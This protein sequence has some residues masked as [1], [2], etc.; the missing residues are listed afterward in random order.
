MKPVEHQGK[1]SLLHATVIPACFSQSDVDVAKLTVTLAHEAKPK[2]PKHVVRRYKLR[3][4][5]KTHD[6][7]NSSTRHVNYQDLP[8][9]SIPLAD[10]G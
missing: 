7:D 4:S 5:I 6:D 9:V 10:T 2:L 1:S 3:G 8:L